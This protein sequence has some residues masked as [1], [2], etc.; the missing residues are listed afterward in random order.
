MRALIVYESMFGNTH[1]IADHIA[2]GLRPGYEVT[3]VPVGDATAEL[4]AAADLLVVGGPTHAHRMSTPG[5]RHSAVDMAHKPD[6]N[7]SLDPDAEGP[8]LRDWFD[9][10]AGEHHATAVAFDTRIN[11]APALSGRASKGIARRLGKHGFP[12]AAEPESFL[13]DKQSRLVAGEA[14]RATT[15]AARLIPAGATAR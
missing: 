1:V 3:V 4:V 14:E 5:T 8:G 12:A 6:S 15:W 7:V 9:A 11:V 10:L 2:T 13:V